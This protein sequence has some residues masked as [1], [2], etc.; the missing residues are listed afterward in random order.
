MEGGRFLGASH[1]ASSSDRRVPVE[2][3]CTKAN[4]CWDP[5]YARGPTRS[6]SRTRRLELRMGPVGIQW[7]GKPDRTQGTVTN[8]TWATT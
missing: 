2:C 7:P 1:H 6:N 3:I 5:N 4:L 8:V